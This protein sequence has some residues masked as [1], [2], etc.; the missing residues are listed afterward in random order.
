MPLRDIKNKPVEWNAIQG[1]RQ[2][3]A[4]VVALFS[5]CLFVLSACC[6][7]D[8]KGHPPSNETDREN[9]QDHAEDL[10]QAAALRARLHRQMSNHQW[11]ARSRGWQILEQGAAISDKEMTLFYT[12]RTVLKSQRA[13]GS[14]QAEPDY[15]NREHLW[16]RSYGLKGTAADRDLHNLVPTDR[17]VN[18][19][20]GN[21]VFDVAMTPHRE[22][23]L[24]R[25][26]SHAWEPPD[27]VKGDIAR[28]LFYMDVRYEG[29]TGIETDAGLPDLT[30][31]EVADPSRRQ[32][33]PL[34]TLL[35]WHCIDPVSPKEE[36]RHEVVAAAQ[37]NRNVFV[38]KPSLVEAVYLFDC[39]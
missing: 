2:P 13:S 34:H 32:L 14:D 33:G 31:T 19:S 27:E 17:T 38:D 10:R 28:I 12:R 37:G 26:D 30:L 36:A 1:T 20:R 22:C 4:P 21:K 18:S 29:D 11:L 39:P 24:C 3:F 23:T 25:V 35:T 5:V 9:A 6:S 15:W 8:N 16:P 7:N